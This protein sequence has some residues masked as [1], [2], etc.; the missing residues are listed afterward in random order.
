[1]VQAVLHPLVDWSTSL[2][3]AS[4]EANRRWSKLIDPTTL[5]SRPISNLRPGVAGRQYGAS[6]GF[7]LYSGSSQTSYRFNYI[8]EV[9]LHYAPGFTAEPSDHRQDFGDLTHLT[10]I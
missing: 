9:K 1:V 7:D 5:T 6:F 3:S 4:V 8:S 10:G 2:R